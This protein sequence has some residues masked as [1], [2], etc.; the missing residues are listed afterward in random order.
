MSW[1]SAIGRAVGRPRSD[2]T[3]PDEI[4][5]PGRTGQRS[6]APGVIRVQ[7]VAGESRQLASIVGQPVG[8][9]RIEFAME[10]SVYRVAMRHPGDASEVVRLID[11]GTLAP[12]A[13]AAIFGKTEGNGCVNDFTRGYALSALSTALAPRLGIAPDA[14]P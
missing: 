5:A 1:Q 9:E 13:I 3:A 6:A 7:E 11:E 2:R 14:V 10:C 8:V 4:E 12:G